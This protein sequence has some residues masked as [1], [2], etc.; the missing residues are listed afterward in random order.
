M[1]FFCSGLASPFRCLQP[2]FGTRLELPDQQDSSF[3]CEGHKAPLLPEIMSVMCEMIVLERY[4]MISIS[5]F[6]NLVS[7][8]LPGPAQSCEP[9]QAKPVSAG[10]SQAIGDG[11]AMA[12]AQLRV[13][14]SQSHRLKPWLLRHC[15]ATL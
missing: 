7:S 4:L 8:D 1:R 5:V 3:G 10:P 9:G 2:T 14:E 6:F 15:F 13:A 12:L 11:P